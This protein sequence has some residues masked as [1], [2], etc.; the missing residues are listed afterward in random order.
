MLSH[1]AFGNIG[2]DVV[3]LQDVIE[4]C[5]PT[6]RIELILFEGVGKQNYTPVLHSWTLFL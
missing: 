6:K 1:F 4:I 5:F 2:E 3:D